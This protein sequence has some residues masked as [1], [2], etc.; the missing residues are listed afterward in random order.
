MGKAMSDRRKTLRELLTGMPR[1][2]VAF[3]GG[4]DSTVLLA[5]AVAD[6]GPAR[7]SAL[8]A[9]TPLLP[10]GEAQEAAARA[11][12][13]GVE[14]GLVP[15]DPLALPQVEGNHRDRCYHCKKDFLSRLRRKAGGAVLL[16]GS[17]ADD[18]H[19]HRPGSR[20]L[21]E[22]GV[23]SPLA[24][25]GLGKMEVRALAREMGLSAADRPSAPCLA[26]RFPYGAAITREGL[27]RVDEGERLLRAEG[28]S[29]F[30]LR[31]HGA[32]ARIELAAGEFP[33]LLDRSRRERVASALRALGW[34]FVALDLDGLRSGSFDRL[35]E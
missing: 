13:L 30:R 28:F 32:V 35:P 18:L 20:A 4:V 5:C 26:T 19:A 6:L 33:L 27:R 17:Q 16:E 3:S 8:T 29:S 24:E 11:R 22:L 21:A 2:A 31:H 7:V 15:C 14:A 1:V 9:D 25:A 10:A 23:R 12:A 34:E